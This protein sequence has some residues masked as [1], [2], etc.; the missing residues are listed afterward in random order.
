MK[1]IT[2]QFLTHN[3]LFNYMYIRFTKEVPITIF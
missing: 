2:K 3:L 1:Y